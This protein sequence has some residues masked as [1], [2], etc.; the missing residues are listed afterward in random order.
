MG[1]WR[2]AGSSGANLEG[3]LEEL[4]ENGVSGLGRAILGV[5]AGIL[6][7]YLT[8]EPKNG[9]SGSLECRYLLLFP[10]IQ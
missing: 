1:T 5:I 6:V 9:S 3:K 2:G 10:W 8:S 4:E 7:R